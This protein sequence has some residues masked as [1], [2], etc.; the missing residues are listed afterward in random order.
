MLVQRRR[1][2]A[3]IKPVL[4]KRLVFAGILDCQPPVG[5]MLAQRQANVWY[6]GP[7]INWIEA[8]RSGKLRQ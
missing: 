6:D 2:W 5:S 8:L 1:R 7:V 4:V 3:N